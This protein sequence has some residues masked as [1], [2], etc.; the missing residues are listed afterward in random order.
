[1][2]K[3]AAIQMVSSPNVDAN[4]IE[5]ERL[6]RAASDAGVGLVVLPENFALM[7]MTEFDKLEHIENDGDGVM[8]NFLADIAK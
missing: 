5:A 2:K 6:I 3:C 1:M 8:Q 7:G 4:L